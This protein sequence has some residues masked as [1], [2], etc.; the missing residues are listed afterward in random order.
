MII[1]D[2][3]KYLNEK[4]PESNACSFDQGKIGLMIGSI[5]NNVTKILCSLDLTYEVAKE[6]VENNVELIIT[7]HPYFFNPLTKIDYDNNVGKTLKLL[8]GNNISC[9]SM[10]TNL[11]VGDGGVNDTLGEMLE[12]I[13]MKVIREEKT[14]N[15]FLRYGDI[16]EI[17]LQDL[18]NKVKK[19][20]GLG[21]VR[22]IGDLNRKVKKI[23]V[24]GGSGAHNNDINEA[25]SCNVDCYI[26]G[27]VKLPEAIRINSEN[28]SLIE[29]NHG[30]ER[31]VF[32]NLSKM[33]EKDLK[34]NVIVS[35]INTDP[36]INM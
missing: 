10:H 21:S 30:V 34:L 16:E 23:G 36:F 4:Y 15:N 9:F 7:H 6:A 5:N 28:L 1:N 24:V 33:I 12:I 13:N 11:D 32:N 29:V 8:L 17:S 27:E 35:N 18:A 2:V 14:L 31:F 26:T 25:I 19:T 22:V 20:F 3:I